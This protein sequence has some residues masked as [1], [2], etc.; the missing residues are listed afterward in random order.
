MPAFETSVESRNVPESAMKPLGRTR[1]R[2]AVLLAG[3]L[4]LV[5]WITVDAGRGY[6]VWFAVGRYIDHL[7]SRAGP[8]RDLRRSVRQ[9]AGVPS[10]RPIS[11]RIWDYW[12][13]SNTED[14]ARYFQELETRFETRHPDVDV[15][16]Q[17]VPF[18]FF[19]QKLAT[20]MIGERPPDVFQCS[21]YW[22]QAMYA[23][24]MLLKLND[25]VHRTPELQDK[26]FFSAALYHSRDHGDI[27][28]I[29]QIFDA[30]CLMWNLDL[31]KTKPEL[32]GL[33]ARNEEGEVDYTRIRFDAVR[34]W[35][36]F[37]RIARTLTD[38]KAGRYGFEI[39]AYQME[40]SAFMGWAAANEVRFQDRSGTRALF[41]TPAGVEALQ[42]VLDLYHEDRVSPP[43]Q[44]VTTS[45]ELFQK[46]EVACSQGGTWLAK[47]IVRNT[48][49]WKGFGMTAFPPGPRGTEQKTQ[50]WGNMLVIGSR[51]KHPDVAWDYLRLVCGPEGAKLRLTVLKHVSPRRDLY[52]TEEW[53]RLVREEPF[54]EN[55]PKI[56]AAGDPLRHTQ[57]AAVQDELVP[58]F[59]YLMLNYPEVKAGRGRYR[60]ATH[61][62]QVAADRVNAVYARYQRVLGD[63]AAADARRG[64]R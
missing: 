39:N 31:L 63:W 3:A 59:E 18:G 19:E 51:C 56:C 54:M 64:D 52:Q 47:H 11:L 21:V 49:G 35:E 27:Y 29:P 26:Q 25:Y 38:R 57:P 34:D 41:N 20:G 55:I 46:G 36:H 8:T 45:L 32:H 5:A 7:T 43:F 61:A 16:Y 42:F 24:G 30:R 53:R 10:E 23:R 58:I 60:D 17:S 6:G 2:R 37:R 22:A 33:F 40:A 62:L 14:F 50:S 44:S 28:G 12:S 15:V 1:F 13:P 4:A 48:L 9:A